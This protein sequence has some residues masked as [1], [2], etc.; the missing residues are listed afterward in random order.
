MYVVG[1]A[2]A[3]Y[4]PVFFFLIINTKAI[5]SGLGCLIPHPLSSPL[6]FL[7]PFVA[8]ALCAGVK[9]KSQT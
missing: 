9:S 3:L 4:I 6:S 1:Y 2:V 7:Q 8:T 5:P